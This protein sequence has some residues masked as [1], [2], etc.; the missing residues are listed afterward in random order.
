MTH[1]TPGLLSAGAR[2]SPITCTSSPHPSRP[3]TAASLGRADSGRPR[4]EGTAE[5]RLPAPLTQSPALACLLASPPNAYE[6]QRATVLVNKWALFQA[7]HATLR[8]PRTAVL[9]GKTAGATRTPSPGARLAGAGGRSCTPRPRP[10][11]GAGQTSLGSNRE[12]WPE[13][14]LWAGGPNPWRL[15]TAH[16][17]GPGRAS[18]AG[19]WPQRHQALIRRTRERDLLLG[20]GSLCRGLRQDSETG[21]GSRSS[22]WAPDTTSS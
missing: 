12:G 4:T 20:T 18:W 14:V 16:L 11:G 17:P 6:R 1:S 21:D 3:L 10:Q 7:S 15:H 19:W 9:R 22:G 5:P 13:G 8:C 2:Q